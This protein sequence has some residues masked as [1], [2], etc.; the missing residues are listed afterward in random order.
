MKEFLALLR[1]YRR[2]IPKQT[3]KTLRGQALAGDVDGAR[4]GLSHILEKTT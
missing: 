3:L 2:T 4:R 1:R